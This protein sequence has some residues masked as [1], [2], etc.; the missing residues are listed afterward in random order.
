M[1]SLVFPFV[2]I[3]MQWAKKEYKDIINGSL[4]NI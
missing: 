1:L 4:L 3:I 2:N